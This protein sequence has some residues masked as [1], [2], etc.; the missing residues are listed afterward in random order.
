ME[1]P[2]C[3]NT[4]SNSCIGSCTHHFCITCLVKWC[5]NKGTSCP[6]CKTLIIEIRP[7]PEFDKINCPELENISTKNFSNTI[8]INF[9][10]DDLPGITLRNN[11]NFYNDNESSPGV[12]ITRINEKDQCYKSGMRKNDIILFINNIPCIDHKQSVDIIDNSV[13]LCRQ[14]SFVLLKVQK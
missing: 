9:I 7:D 10:K 11:S 12:I 13:R 1:C 2:I 3:Y 14:V 8:T 6:I 4:I 5:E